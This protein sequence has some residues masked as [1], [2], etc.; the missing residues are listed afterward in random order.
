MENKSKIVNTIKEVLQDEGRSQRWL[1][2][3][4]GIHYTT[5]NGYL[6]NERQP[7]ADILFKI[8][9]AL[10]RSMDSLVKEKTA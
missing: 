8:A 6:N 5:M 10:G 2:K 7:P 4:V 1:S 3:K 9:Q